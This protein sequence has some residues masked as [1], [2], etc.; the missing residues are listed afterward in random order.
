LH[1]IYPNGNGTSS[2]DNGL[3]GILQRF[4]TA[5]FHFHLYSNNATINQSTALAS[6][7]EQAA[8]GYALAAVASGAFTLVGVT[9][10]NGS[11]MAAPVSFG[12]NTSGG[13]V[14]SYGYYVTDTSN[15]VLLAVA[16]FDSAP[17]ATA[18]GGTFPVVVPVFGDFSQYT[19]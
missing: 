12:T 3:I 13:S 6:L 14:N 1:Q 8:A 2:G 5:G 15:T 17:I 4:A 16:E 10:N 7:T 18:N 19:S 11:I 9:A